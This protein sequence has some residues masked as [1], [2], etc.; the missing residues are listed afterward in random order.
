MESKQ[1]QDYLERS[2]PQ[3]DSASIPRL[4]SARILSRQSLLSAV[5]TDIPFDGL[6]FEPL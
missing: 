6:F 2:L 1:S 5:A 4:L 3:S